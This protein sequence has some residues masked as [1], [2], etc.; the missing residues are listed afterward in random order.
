MAIIGENF[1]LT[2]AAR[3][4]NLDEIKQGASISSTK[5]PGK[6]RMPVYSIP[7]QYLIYNPYNTRFLTQAKT[8]ERRFGCRLSDENP[9]HLKAIEKFI[10][11]EKKDKNQSTLYSLIK[12]GQLQPGVVT[13]DG[14]ILAGNRRFRLLNEIIRNP[15][16]YEDQKNSIVGL[17]HFEAVILDEAQLERKEIIEYESFYQFGIEDKVEYDPIQKYIAAYIQKNELGFTEKQIASHFASIT[18]GDSSIVKVWLKVYDYMD[19][20]LKYIGEDGIYTALN[21]RE[22][23]FL[24][25]RRLI[26]SYENGRAGAKGWAFNNFDLIELKIVFFDYIRLNIPTH[27]FR[28]FKEIFSDEE[29]WKSFRD[30]EKSAIDDENNQVA[31]FD[32]YRRDYPEEDESGISKIRQND[33]IGKVKKELNRL[34]GIENGRIQDEKAQQLPIE[35]LK[36]IQQ[37]LSKLEKDMSING[38]KDTYD[39]DE[40]LDAIRDIQKRIG[41]IK[42]KVD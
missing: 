24:S 30:K 6:G 29:Q 9:E 25:L 21:G 5:V 32:E 20:Y 42:Q 4:K 40:F 7:L 27:D 17:D 13:A 22:E 8:L 39:S 16:K 41:R 28:I 15:D 1:P 36:S 11:E 10:W 26:N 2:K 33:Y 37:K 19:E 18:E 31:S 14:I 23:A 35:I 34:Y 38:S 12:D 3:K